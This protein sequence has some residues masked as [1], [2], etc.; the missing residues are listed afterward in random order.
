MKFLKKYK[1]SI[2][3]I[4]IL[5]FTILLTLHIENKFQTIDWINN[6]YWFYL[7]ITILIVVIL[8]GLKIYFEVK[9]NNLIIENEKKHKELV[10]KSIK[11]KNENK[12][13]QDLISS[14][15]YQISKPLEDKLHDIYKKLNFNSNH[16]ITIYTYTKGCFFSIA[17]YS[18]NQNYT[19]F[20]RIAI[21]SEDE[22]IFKVWNGEN[23]CASLSDSKERKMPTKKIC[24]HFLYEKNEVHPEKDKIGLV[25][26]ES[27]LKAPKQFN[28]GKFSEHV[29]DINSF[30]NEH[31]EIKQ[32]LKFAMQEDL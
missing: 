31:M 27:T 19:S 25:V 29:K 1:T 24:A 7:S 10:L 9:E 8:T 14:F 28:N 6:S 4:A 20:G 32:D 21:T 3:D 2:I 5:I 13:L 17:R 23:N 12:Y 15:K 16:R 11:M 18:S 22:F 30:I 26:F